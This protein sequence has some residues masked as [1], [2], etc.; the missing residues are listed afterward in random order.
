MSRVA[1]APGM[2]AAALLLAALVPAPA[3]AEDPPP[4]AV[5]DLVE[6]AAE[7]DG[8]R[9]A[10]EGEAIGSPMI[11][12]SGAWVNIADRSGA[13][14]VWMGAETARGIARFGS[15][16]AVGDTLRVTGVFHRACAE[17]G[18][19]M[20]VHAD[21]TIVT[22]PGRP[23]A[24]PVPAGRVVAALALAL[25][26]AGAVAAL[27]AFGQDRGPRTPPPGYPGSAKSS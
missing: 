16:G 1:L 25:V 3:C 13:L 23:V 20:D 18:G 12:D 7:L 26:A 14:G 9:V 5:T 8:R 15:Y 21:G 22:A 17:H 19:D 24:H 10:L 6:R 11:R 27:A 2:A 4:S